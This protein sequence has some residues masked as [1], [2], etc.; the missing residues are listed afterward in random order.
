MEPARRE[1]D[2]IVVGTGPG[3]ATVARELTRRKRRVLM[4][5]WGSAEPIKGTP[6]QA[7]KWFGIPGKDILITDRLLGVVRA[8]CTGGSTIFYYGTC[9]PTPFEM[10]EKYGVHIRDEV[11]EARGELPV[12]PLKDE[13]VSPMARRIMDS[14]V[15]L[16]YDWR[17]LDKYMYQDRWQPDFPFGYYGDPH[18]VR[19]DAR[20]FVEEALENGAAIIN[21]ARVTRVLVENNKAVGVEYAS[22]GATHRAYAADVV[23][24]AGGLGSPVI[25][26]NSG[27]RRAGYDF[28]F[29]PLI[30]VCG[31]VKDVRA[32][33]SEI[34]MTAGLHLEEEGYMMT[35]MSVPF[36][37]DMLFTAQV[38]RFHRM[39][40]QRKMLRIMIKAQDTLG[41]RITDR[42]GVR[43]RLAEQD[44]Q[45]LLR[46]AARAREILQHA[47]A[48]G[49]FNSWY[50]ASHPGGTVKIGD[51]LDAGL[52]TEYDHL[53]VCDC[54]VIP[55]A[56]GL[57]P[58]LTL[59]GL[60]KYLAKILSGE[61][62]AP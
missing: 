46:G 27:M 38:F 33:V 1:Y 55:E 29:D 26:R 4:L 12:A 2:A 11:A 47:G 49:I 42:G 40:S 23:I 56:W 30:T 35:D 5:E 10:L 43:K 25:L 50:L 32:R 48:K 59:I 13:M 6:W 41:G 62:K 31:E 60:G 53:Y 37:L 36:L 3:G 16:G 7:F 24:S 54:S 45:K 57:P 19:W 22:G 28:F 44:R 17:L 20:M 39:F 8:V 15:S 52:K 18:R 51:I 61:K 14:A 58:T 9:F 21:H 34:P